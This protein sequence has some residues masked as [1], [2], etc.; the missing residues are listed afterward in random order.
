MV[1]N[2]C[3]LKAPIR[4]A[5][6]ITLLPLVC[7]V[8]VFPQAS[9]SPSPSVSG[10]LAQSRPETV[11]HAFAAARSLLQQGKYEEAVSQLSDLASKNPGLKGLSSELGT[12]YY[13]KGDYIKA[14]EAFKQALAEDPQNK[15]AVQL[16]GLSYYLSG[17]PSEAIP[18]LE[19]V[20][21]WY[22]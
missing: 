7:S 8:D 10:D 3:R 19:K 5:R 9:S 14:I 4:W 17:K 22:P 21:T 16:L 6:W 15:E 11:D 1:I 13:R 18:L 12:A 20:Q 2:S